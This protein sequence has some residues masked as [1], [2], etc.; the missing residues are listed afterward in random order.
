MDSRFNQLFSVFAIFIV[1]IGFGVLLNLDDSQL[2]NSGLNFNNLF[3][4]EGNLLTGAAIGIESNEEVVILEEE[5]VVEESGGDLGLQVDCGDGP[6]TCACGDTLKENYNLSFDL[7]CTDSGITIG[8]PNLVFDCRGHSITGDGG[9]GPDTGFINTGGFRNIT[10]KN[11]VIGGFAKGIEFMHAF[12]ATIWNN[13]IGHINLTEPNWGIS[14]ANCSGANI[15]N[16]IITNMTSSAIDSVFGIQY[17]EVPTVAS[18]NDVVIYGNNIS[19]IYGTNEFLPIGIGIGDASFPTLDNVKIDNNIIENINCTTSSTDLCAT[20]GGGIG[21]KISSG[22]NFNISNNQFNYLGTGIMPDQ[23]N[24]RI[25]GNTFKSSFNGI[26]NLNSIGAA[27]T[28]FNHSWIENNTFD[29]LTQGVYL[30]GNNHNNTFLNNNF[31]N[32]LQF[33][34]LDHTVSNTNNT[35]I[36]NSTMGEIKWNDKSNISVN[37][38]LNV[39]SSDLY[40]ENGTI[41][42]L[43]SVGAYSLNDTAQITFKGLAHSGTPKMLKDGVRCDDGIACNIT[44]YSGGILVANIA[45]FSNYT[46]QANLSCGETITSNTNMDVILDGCTGDGLVIGASNIILNCSGYSIVGDGDAGDTGITN[47]GYINITIE[48]CIVKNFGTGINFQHAVNATIWNNTVGHINLTE[49]NWGISFSNCS[50]AN[51]SNNI[52]TNM[53]SSNIDSAFGIMYSE[54]PNSDLLYDAVLYNNT[55]SYI[56]GTDNAVP[57]AISIGDGTLLSLNNVKLD[58]NIINNINCSTG[59]TGICQ[60]FGGIGLKVS[61]GT[62]INITNNQFNYLGTGIMPDQPGLR[63]TGNNF[64]TSSYGIYALNSVASATT[65]FNHSWIENNTFDGLTQAVYLTGNNHNNTFL[66][67]NFSNNIHF[68]ILDYTVSTTNNSVI[69]N[70]TMGEIKWDKS[71]ITVNLTLFVNSSDLYIEN[72][73]IG[74]LNGINMFKLNDTAQLIFRGLAYSAAPFLLKDGTRCDNGNACNITY[75]ASTGVLLAN[76][77]SFSNYTLQ[78]GVDTTLPYFDPTPTNQSVEYGSEFNYDVNGTDDTAVGNYS[79]NDTTQFRINGSGMISNATHLHYGVIALNVSLNDSSNNVNSTI[80]FINITDTT[81]PYFNNT[82]TNQS[83]EYGSEFLYDLNGSDNYNVSSFTVN[84]TSQFKINS[85]GHLT[86]V[87]NLHYGVI[88]VNVSI[89]DTFNNTNSTIIFVNITD[90]TPPYFNNTPT[91]Q[92]AE[93]LVNF[94]YDIN[95]S[96]NYNVSTFTINDTVSFKINSSGALVN[97]TNNVLVGFYGINISVND[98]FNNTNSTVIFI[99]VS[100]TIS[101]T[102]DVIGPVGP[103]NGTTVELMLLTSENASCYYKN[104]T[105]GYTRFNVTLA[106]TT[107]Q[108]ILN[109]SFSAG[110]HQY[111]F[112]CND[113]S[114][115]NASAS[116]ILFVT[117]NNA[118]NSS[119][120][121]STLTANT[122]NI[123]DLTTELNLTFNV[124]KDYSPAISVSMH[125]Y[126]TTPETSAFAITGSTV[127]EFKYYVID[128]PAVS[129][130][131]NKITMRFTYNETDVVAAGIAEADLKIYYYNATAG[132]WTEES[133]QGVDTDLNHLEVNVTHLSTFILGKAAVT[134]AAAAEDSS[135][136]SGSSSSGSS[137]P[138]EPAPSSGSAAAAFIKDDAGNVLDDEDKVQGASSKLDEERRLGMV[139]WDKYKN[140][141]LSLSGIL[142]GILVLVI[143]GSLFLRSHHDL[144]LKRRYNTGETF[145]SK[146]KMFFKKHSKVMKWIVISLGVLLLLGVLVYLIYSSWSQIVSFFSKVWAWLY[147]VG[148][149]NQFR[150][151]FIALII[152]LVIG[153]LFIRSHHEFLLKKKSSKTEKVNKFKWKTFFRK[154]KEV[155]K[156]VSTIVIILLILAA[157]GYLIYFYFSAISSFFS[158]IWSW[159]FN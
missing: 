85:S 103:T 65:R 98:T 107:H 4:S 32:I 25:V 126:N 134:A 17:A 31:S 117:T 100:D 156:L 88:G 73:T 75:D 46:L 42:L 20:F 145:W 77:S 108:H 23:P 127:T 136:S 55:I 159:L 130:N 35:V 76:V 80:I 38:S 95:G 106:N 142:I 61:S 6:G 40:I 144:L 44:S 122:S 57:I 92:S 155:I 78:E 66:N 152:L 116:I 97:K 133:E 60:T 49:P 118:T 39:N 48:N 47:I 14:F 137:L 21:L 86:N 141:I 64:G 96:D 138:P 5:I 59:S 89:N 52:I 71:N 62:N 150:G 37:L 135:G 124:S 53:T 94:L 8:G 158:G 114:N 120:V 119:V 84:D 148:I 104:A 111:N 149:L 154:H 121:S 87:S 110:N 36:Y 10:I 128:A 125:K 105:I 56:Y 131:I 16:N 28:R 54:S 151:I 90:T 83:V 147:G 74:L 18:L 51:I 58:S 15:S 45:S 157:V 91:N 143:I 93:Y 2:N 27:S 99:N 50:E 33:S 146:I 3:G 63:M 109:N 139:G 82:P 81:P 112:F 30:L 79:V 102:I 43:N 68:A 69:Y 123:L 132:T 101:A 113:T 115:N 29:G 1:V 24:L 19:R 34:I 9:G 70:S 11:C 67:N 7:S 13:T 12:N 22:T 153:A 72:G 129:G 26:Y 41:G 140:I